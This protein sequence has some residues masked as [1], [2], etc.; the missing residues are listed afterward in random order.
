[1]VPRA[2]SD[3][4]MMVPEELKRGGKKRSCSTNKLLGDYSDDE[5]PLEVGMKTSAVSEGGISG[6]KNKSPDVERA[7]SEPSAK[8][9]RKRLL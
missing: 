1:M 3:K 9:P 5:G 7:K 6:S 2:E 4:H 8:T